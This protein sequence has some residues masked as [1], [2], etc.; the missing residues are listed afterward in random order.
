MKKYW[1]ILPVIFM[2]TIQEAFCI[3]ET[4]SSELEQSLKTQSSEP[5]VLSIIFALLFVIFL[6]YI[7]G[8]VYSKLNI[9]GA[10]TVKEQLKNVNLNRAVVLSTTQLGQ[11]KNLHVIEINDKCYLIGATQN[12]ISLIKELGSAAK[13]T[14]EEEPEK[15]A[16]EDIDTAIR[17]LY[18][19][20]HNEID[21]SQDEN[22]EEFNVHKKYL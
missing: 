12:S 1:F 22:A 13:E 17:V 15:T 8:I 4:V 20:S 2:L 6:I 18:G 16:D 11:G 3:T 10:K 7:T 14:E 19:T 9:V 21:E 5:N